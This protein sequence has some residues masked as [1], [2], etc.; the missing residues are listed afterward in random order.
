MEIRAIT[1][2]TDWTALAGCWDKAGVCRIFETLRIAG[3]RDVYWRVF[4]GGLAL[5]PSRIAEI[6]GRQCYDV[7]TGNNYLPFANRPI[8]Y[9][10]EIDFKRF[11]PIPTALEVAAEF[12]INLHLW[13]TIYEDEHGRPCRSRFN[14][15]HPEWWHTDR[16][17]RQYSGTFDWFYEEV[18][19]YKLAIVD[20]LL[21]YPAK[22]LMLDLVR[23][24]AT[25]SADANGVYRFGYNPAVRAAFQRRAGADPL[26]LPPDHPEWLAFRRDIHTALIREIRDRMDRTG[27]R[28]ELALMLWPVDYARWAGFD[29]RGLSET[30]AAQ[31]L[32]M[33]SLTY[34]LRP[35]D[36]RDHYNIGRAQ[37][38][39]ERVLVL[40]GLSTY[41]GVRGPHIDRFAEA[42]E[43]AGARGIMLYEADQLVR[44]N[45]ASTVRAINLGR[46]NYRRGLT[47]ARLP[48]GA[49]PEQINWATIPAFDNFLFH[50]GPG[51]E[52]VPSERTKF[53]IAYN[54]AELIVRFVCEDRRMAAALAPAQPNHQHQYYIDALRHRG[55]Y[56]GLNSFSLMLDPTRA[57]EDFHLFGATPR[58]ESIT[59]MFIDED[60]TC[61]WSMDVTTGPDR[62]MGVMRIPFAALGHPPP[63]PGDTWGINIVR[64]I[65]WAGEIDIWFPIEGAQVC[66]HELGRLD[67]MA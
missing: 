23:H 9:L 51:S 19:A 56:Y 18:R 41:N 6:Q 22:G 34:S 59:A 1:T 16:A 40:P 4:N 26:A 45:C 3:I 27:R 38:P 24:N 65:C 20:E 14:A 64:G 62:W 12:G 35:Q 66:P 42:A 15:D 55:P 48:A 44:F 25:A 33:C 30:G 58:K 47:A 52:Q 60:W 61:A 54:A 8:H 43:Q 29:V 57:C 11:N 28:M 39:N 31:M 7:S 36:A 63:E 2:F 21:Q 32:A 37:A 13:Y 53:Q 49:G 50:Y 67:F 5:Y 46:P 17:G 10:R